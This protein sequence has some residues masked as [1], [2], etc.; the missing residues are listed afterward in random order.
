MFME[1]PDTRYW[2]AGIRDDSRY[3]VTGAVGDAVYQS[4]T[5]YT[6]AGTLESSATSRRDSDDLT[7]ADDGTFSVVLSREQP[8]D[9]S[10][11]MALPEGATAVW[12]RHFHH[13]VAA[14]EDRKSTRLNSS[15]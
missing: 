11:W 13:D 1:N 7:I 3:R 4:I 10:D 12:V 6:S 14:D 5:V 9:G 2:V 15:H 8:G